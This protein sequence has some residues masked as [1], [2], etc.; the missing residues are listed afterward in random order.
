MATVNLATG[1]NLSGYDSFRRLEVQSG[2][3]LSLDRY[4]RLST[5]RTVLANELV[6]GDGAKLYMNV[7]RVPI[8][9]VRTRIGTGAKIYVSVFASMGAVHKRLIGSFG[10][11]EGTLDESS[12][13]IDNQG[14]V[15][16][17]ILRSG[18]TFY[19]SA[20]GSEAKPPTS[21]PNSRGYWTG[22]AGN[23]LWSDT[24]NWLDGYIPNQSSYS[25]EYS[26]F[27][28]AYG[29]SVVNDVKDRLE[30]RLLQFYK[31]DTGKGAEDS[32]P[33]ILSGKSIL[34][35]A[36][37][38]VYNTGAARFPVIISNMLYRLTGT[39]QFFN[40]SSSDDNSVTLA[41]G[42]SVPGSGNSYI[43]LNGDW[44]LGGTVTGTA[45]VNGT[46][47]SGRFNRFSIL[48]GASVTL[49]SQGTGTNNAL[50]VRYNIESN[51]QLK[52]TGGTSLDFPAGLEVA[53]HTIYGTLDVGIPLKFGVDQHFHGTGEVKVLSVD[54]FA[55]TKARVHLS[56]GV[57][58]KPAA[59]ATATAAD[60]GVTAITVD[61][62]ATIA[63]TADMTYGAADVGV[64]STP[65]ERALEIADAGELTLVAN[66]GRTVT[67]SDPISGEGKLIISGAG[68]V[69]LAGGVTVGELAVSGS[70]KLKV[71]GDNPV[72]ASNGLSLAGVEMDVADTSGFTSWRTVLS[73]SEIT[74]MPTLPP[75]FKAKVEVVDGH[76]ELRLKKLKGL[77]ITIH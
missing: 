1:S 45:L 48:E 12:F 13:V 20:V 67:F 64:T 54:D 57:T 29:W 38:S 19:L 42:L 16:W 51:G 11:V 15:E 3:S 17:Q 58:L 22:A 50:A 39:A 28:D 6:L 9:A 5:F 10:D 26:D 62:V 73:A 40:A 63:P 36:G 30:V 23:G 14:S 59:W 43:S 52:F 2:A 37:N 33:Y 74:G 69:A 56:G 60:D 4:S 24:G 27:Y 66:E 53:H 49:S 47:S 44:R 68:T 32:G 21:R 35:R 7:A 61:G 70:P 31:F 8:D 65:Q 76:A 55:G 46:R 77:V 18:N 71:S 75:D 34:I 72:V 41:G 25:S